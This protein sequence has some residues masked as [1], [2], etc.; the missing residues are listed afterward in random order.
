M[1]RADQVV[2]AIVILVAVVVLVES[3]SLE[4]FAGSGL[5]PG[6]APVAL[7]IALVSLGVLLL[8]VATAQPSDSPAI[9]WPRGRPRLVVGL[10]IADL[11]AYPC[12]I[13]LVGYI[14]ATFI[15]MW[16]IVWLFGR[17]RWYTA[18]AA[19]LALSVGMYVVFELVLSTQLP[20]GALPIP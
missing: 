11:F 6:F 9:C 4:L 14:V 8:I 1:R 15:F 2:A 12:L 13:P 16:P 20:S 3:R 7:A 17:Y 18:T 5:G 19:A 10:T